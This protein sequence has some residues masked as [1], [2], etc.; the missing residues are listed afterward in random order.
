MG[1][2]VRGEEEGLG[3][4][5]DLL[6]DPAPDGLPGPGGGG[7]PREDRVEV[8]EPGLEEADERGLARPVD[9][10]E[11]D[12]DHAPLLTASSGTAPRWTAVATIAPSYPASASRSRSAVEAT[13]PP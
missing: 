11:R 4:R 13:P 8:G 9:P 5:V 1:R 12:Q 2:V 6:G 7:L 3:D 10:L